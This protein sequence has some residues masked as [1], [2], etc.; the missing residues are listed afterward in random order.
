MKTKFE[1]PAL[2][3]MDFIKIYEQ[4]IIFFLFLEFYKKNKAIY[5]N[6]GIKYAATEHVEIK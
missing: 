2:Y 5:T 6:I 1:R 3:G 4:C